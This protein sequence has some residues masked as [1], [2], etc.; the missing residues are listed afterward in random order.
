M[1]PTAGTR[2]IHRRLVATLVAAFGVVGWLVASAPAAHAHAVL[3]QTTPAA[4]AVVATAPA[5]VTLRFGEQVAVQQGSVRVFD[6][7][8]H[9]VD[10]G[11]THHVGGSGSVV[12]VDL[13]RTLSAGTY[14]VTWRVISADSH[15]VDGS[16]TFS[17]GH[18]STVEGSV[19]RQNHGSRAVGVLLGVARL[20]GYAGLVCCVGVG[21]VLIVLWPAGR[22]FAKS[23]R[24]VWSGWAGPRN[25]MQ[26]LYIAPMANPWTI[27]GPRVE[28]SRPSAL[29]ERR[30]GPAPC[31]VNEGPAV[32][33]YQGR[34]VISFSANGFWSDHYC[35]GLLSCD[36]ERLLEPA[37]WSKSNRPAFAPTDELFGTG[38]N[39]LLQVPHGPDAGWWNLYHASRQPR[40]EGKTRE[41]FAQPFTWHNGLPALGRP[42]AQQHEPL[43]LERLAS[44]VR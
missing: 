20:V 44:Q 22:R 25:E 13:P 9:R 43:P 28:I 33:V 3:E 1:A 27:C 18:P 30:S 10:V 2:A 14:T 37:A 42:G 15:P 5:Q 12:G 23:R 41:L 36:L 32:A 31:Y 19:A 39:C 21:L 6:P 8:L 35:L 34:V 24:L 29:W 40:R 38:H 16:F 4:G 17:I 7:G 26:R 11:G